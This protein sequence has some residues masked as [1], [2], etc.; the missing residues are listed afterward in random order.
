M[1]DV[2]LSYVR[3]DQAVAQTIAKYLQTRGFNV[4][5]DHEA[6]VAG[7]D[8]AESIYKAISA[9]RVVVV[10]LS[11][12]SKRSSW[13]QQELAQALERKTL[14]VPVL[15]DEGAK[16]NWVWPLLSRWQALEVGKSQKSLDDDLARLAESIEEAVGHRSPDAR[17][18]YGS[19][20]RSSMR[21][22]VA[23]LVTLGAVWFLLPRLSRGPEVGSDELLALFSRTAEAAM[24]TPPPSSY[25][26]PVAPETDDVTITFPETGAGVPPIL[27]LRGTVSNESADIWVVVHPIQTGAYWVQ[28]RVTRT[29]GEWTS[30]VFFGRQDSRDAGKLFDVRVFVGPR[31][32]LREGQILSEWPDAAGSSRAVLVRRARDRP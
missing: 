23:V 22:A 2:F 15:L 11:S 14:V 18:G 1:Y 32:E 25:K 31:M 12:R 19:A 7:H 8:Y 3:D 4:F 10:L 13:V 30:V 24:E 21:I 16:E 27:A 26:D 29:G 9:S 5:F 20:R 6:L 17:S 28:P